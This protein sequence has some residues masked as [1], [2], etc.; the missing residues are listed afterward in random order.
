MKALVV[1][2]ALVLLSLTI[3]PS[4]RAQSGGMQGMDMVGKDTK[5][6]SHNGVGTVKEVDATAGTVTI[7]HGPVADLKWPAMTMT[8]AVK[9]RMLLDK[10]VKNRKINFEFVQQDGN[11]VVTSVK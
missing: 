7:A 11:Y 9:D 8:F 2:S 3:T 5:G 6:K 1:L 4:S 10:M